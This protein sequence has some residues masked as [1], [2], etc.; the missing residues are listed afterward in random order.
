MLDKPVLYRRTKERYDQLP[1]EEQRECVRR[2]YAFCSYED[3]LFGKLLDALEQTGLDR[4]TIVIYCSD[5]GDY[6]GSHGLWAKGL[7]CFCLLYTS[8]CV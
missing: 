4:N 7:P 8:R 6:I 1:P 2:F 3:A 5:H